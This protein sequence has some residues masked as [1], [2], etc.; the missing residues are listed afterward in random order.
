MQD[1]KLFWSPRSPFA[2]KVT[3]C[4]HELGLADAIELV[5]VVV[6]TP[7]VNPEVSLHNPLSKIPALIL[8]DGSTI[9]DSAVI[10]EYLN[11][12]RG[13]ELVPSDTTVRW[14][15]LTVQAVA[16]GLLDALILLRN[17][18]ARP[19]PDNAIAEALDRKCA[20]ALDW[21]ENKAGDLGANAPTVGEITVGC[22][23]L[24]LDF[25]F[26]SFNWRAGRPALDALCSALSA[27]PSFVA[28]QHQDN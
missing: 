23:L 25:R 5:P 15:A 16:D 3:V 24:Y 14:R 4:A 26:A 9:L 13:A 2:R 11:A 21:L 22:A 7:L 10:C 20:Q 27:R 18:R 6:A 12:V 28:T 8:R 19:T 17:E 1:M